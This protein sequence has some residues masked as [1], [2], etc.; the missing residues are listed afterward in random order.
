VELGDVESA[1]ER[2]SGVTRAVVVAEHETLTAYVESPEL[3]DARAI[4]EH[5]RAS[6]PEY[7]VPARYVFV[8]AMPLTPNGKLDKARLA[9]TTS[10]REAGL[11]R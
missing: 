10:G 1:L 2:I 9:A 4:R 3:R 6:L 5:A 8:D 11:R 7:M